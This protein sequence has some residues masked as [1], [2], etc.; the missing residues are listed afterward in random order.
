MLTG[1]IAG[2][3]GWQIMEFLKI[4]EFHGIPW[5]SLVIIVPILWI[6]GVL[7]GYFLGQW[8]EFFNQFGKFAAIG[9]TNFAVSAGVLNLLLAHTGYVKGKG[10]SLIN[11]IAFVVSLLASY[12]WNK[13]WAFKSNGNSRSSGQ[14]VKFFLV[15]I[16]TF[17]VNLVIASAVVNFFHPA[18]GLD[19]HQ[20][21]NVGTI[22]GAAIGLIISFIG[23]RVAVFK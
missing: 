11:S 4:A 6:L 5:S 16:V 14:F 2:T 17:V 19:A 21:A 23:F 15:T 3:I 22:L 8:M 12:V 10:Y 20:W 1:L 7:L 13:Y 18:F 9:F